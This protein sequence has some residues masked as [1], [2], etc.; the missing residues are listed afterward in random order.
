M[1][2]QVADFL[3]GGYL[4]WGA[5]IGLL[6]SWLRIGPAGAVLA[7]FGVAGMIA[8]GPVAWWAAG[9]VLAAAFVRDGFEALRRPVVPVVV[10]LVCAFAL[11]T[12]TPDTEMARCLCGATV[13][14]GAGALW[15]RWSWS[16]AALVV[17]VLL[18]LGAAVDGRTR[19]SAVIGGLGV[20]AVHGLVQWRPPPPG[21]RELV[22]VLVTAG[23]SLLCARVAGLADSAG[24]AVGVVVPTVAVAAGA[25]RWLSRPRPVTAA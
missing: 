24:F 25:A 21:W 17:T 14:A 10:S 3:A 6:L 5:G 12:S 20:A 7:G 9:P 1:S 22:S 2:D 4:A 19:A 11:Y 16:H 18:A 23:A 8:A 13:G 15:Q